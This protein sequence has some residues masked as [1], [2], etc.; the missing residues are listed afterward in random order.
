MGRLL[1]RG[2]EPEAASCV[3]PCGASAIRDRGFGCCKGMRAVG[4]H[5]V[6][7]DLVDGLAFESIHSRDGDTNGEDDEVGLPDRLLGQPVLD[8]HRPLHLDMDRVPGGACRGL[9]A[10]SRHV[11]VRDPSGARGH[12]DDVHATFPSRRAL[13]RS[14]AS[15][16]SCAVRACVRF[17][18]KAACM[19][20]RAS[21]ASIDMYSAELTVAGT[22]S[23]NTSRARG[24]D[25]SSPYRMP[26][27]DRPKAIEGT[28][29][30]LLRA[31][32]TATPFSM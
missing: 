17:S 10:L 15:S 6:G 11:R 7:V 29:T 18:R 25:S 21:I 19:S 3:E 16:T 23:M 14:T 9:Q 5:F 30:A 2:V 1:P 24:A 31:C 13:A 22:A 28:R 26:S 27:R 8:P 32:G 12:R 4:Q 20:K